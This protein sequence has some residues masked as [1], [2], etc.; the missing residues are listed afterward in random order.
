MFDFD[1]I[2]LEWSVSSNLLQES[3]ITGV[4]SITWSNYRKTRINILR[5]NKVNCYCE[6]LVK[7]YAF[8]SNSFVDICNH[9][10]SVHMD[11]VLLL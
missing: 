5:I 8:K 10:T 1:Q 9:Y 7:L 4:L 2:W 3:M 11:K 6:V